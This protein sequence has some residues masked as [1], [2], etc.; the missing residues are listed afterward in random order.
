MK[1]YSML[2]TFYLSFYSRDLYQDVR[3][4]WKGTGFL[5]LLLLLALTWLPT[6]VSVHGNLTEEIRREAPKY[7]E[8]VPKITVVRG[9]VSIDRPV[10]YEIADPATGEPFAV[11]DTSGTITAFEQTKAPV[12][13]TKTKFMYRHPR[14]AETRIYDLTAIEDLTIDRDDVGRWVELFRKY[15]SIAAYPFALAGSFVLRVLQVLI[16]A[17]IGLLF[18]AMLRAGLDYP[19]LLRLTSVAVTPAIV[20]KM[21]STAAGIH[22]PAPGLIRFAV[23]MGYLFFAVKANAEPEGTGT[24]AA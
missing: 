2:Q 12:L 10:P 11:I 16:Y 8:Q 6:M 22:F 23:A 3:K 21:L 24:P 5:Y 9:E 15:F 1:Q 20:L 18:V 7:I 17:A 14:R 4:N 13:L 19:V